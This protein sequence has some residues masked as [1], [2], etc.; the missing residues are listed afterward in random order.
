IF[1]TYL[2]LLHMLI[3]LLTDIFDNAVADRLLGLIGQAGVE[4]AIQSL[5]IMMIL[6]FAVV[7][8][9][10]LFIF[11]RFREELKQHDDKY[12]AMR[13]AMQEIGV[14]IFYSSSTILIAM[15]VL[16]FATFGDYK[17]FAPIFSIA[18]VVVMIDSVTLIPTLFTLF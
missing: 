12:H 6:L 14:P 13:L 10:S 2:S 8:D 4:L 16:F 5:S 9:Y 17:N 3:S 15:L 11:S 18:V 7:I 1:I